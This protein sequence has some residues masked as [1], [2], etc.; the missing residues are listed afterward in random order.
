VK[1][2]RE[3]INLWL[4]NPDYSV[5]KIASLT[6]Q[7]IG[8]V[9]NIVERYKKEKAQKA[10]RAIKRYKRKNYKAI[11]PLQKLDLL[12]RHDSGEPVTKIT[13]E[14]GISRTIFYKWMREFERGMD[15]EVVLASRRPRGEAHWRFISGVREMVLEVIAQNPAASL[16]GIAQAVNAQGKTVSRSGLYYMLKNMQ[17][18]SYEDRLAYLTRRETASSQD[19]GIAKGYAISAAAA[20]FLP[21]F[22][23]YTIFWLVSILLVLTSIPGSVRYDTP[24]NIGI[25]PSAPSPVINESPGGKHEVYIVRPT[26]SNQDFRWGAAAVNSPRSAYAPGEDIKL[27]FGVVDHAGNTVCDGL[28]GWEIVDPEGD[29]VFESGVSGEG[30]VPSG[31]AS[32]EPRRSGE[33]SLQSVTDTPDYLASIGPVKNT[34]V[35]KLN[36]DVSTYEGRREFSTELVVAPNQ[37]FEITRSSYPTRVFP[38]AVYP[39]EFKIK[40]KQDFRG[41][42]AESLPPGIT[43]SSV[44]GGGIIYKNQARKERKVKWA[45]DM[46]KD[47]TYILASICTS[48]K[49]GRSSTN[50]A[51]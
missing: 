23:I 45:V 21:Q 24:G 48:L 29:K 49:S 9:F 32:L 14:A 3:V 7:S 42:I 4:N 39:V 17:L 43:A 19:E 36:F 41:T 15:K 33:C 44:S 8:G 2:E 50:S 16:S 12:K 20:S 26:R 10:P 47:K 34:G 22:A 30:V 5:R 31:P 13:K 27:G 51:R 18:A 6:G 11:T 40:A 35:Y 37:P 38:P 46:K 1:R 28:I 25:S